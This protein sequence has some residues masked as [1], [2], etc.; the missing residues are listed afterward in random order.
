MLL[1]EVLEIG[2]ACHG[3]ILVHDLADYAGRAQPSEAGQIDGPFGLAGSNE[4][5]TVTRA[6]RVHMPR[7]YQVFGRRA[8]VGSSANGMRAIGGTDAGANASPRLDAHRKCRTERRPWAIRLLHHRQL[9]LVH[10]M[11]GKR[12]ANQAA[13]M[14]RHEV[15]GLCGHTIGGDAQIALILTVLVIDQNDHSTLTDLIDGVLNSAQT[16]WVDV[17]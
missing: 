14:R 8:R 15:D 13:S 7:H 12:E 1:R 6:Q 3:S 11:L 16:P 4:N 2:H 10:L 9:E 17:E 5:A